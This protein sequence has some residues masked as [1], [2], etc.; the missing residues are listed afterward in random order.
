MTAETVQNPK[1]PTRAVASSS[2]RP[3]MSQK[4]IEDPVRLEAPEG[5]NPVKLLKITNLQ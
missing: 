3:L 2:L 4:A 1:D 5:Y